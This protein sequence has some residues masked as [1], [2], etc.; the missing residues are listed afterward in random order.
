MTLKAMGDLIL[1]CSM[2]IVMLIARVLSPSLLSS[3]VCTAPHSPMA[4][5]LPRGIHHKY[6]H[7]PVENLDAANLR[8][9]RW[10]L[11]LSGERWEL[12]GQGDKGEGIQKYQLV[13]TKSSYM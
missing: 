3:S 4:Q 12:G 10:G 13:A 2:S 5:V 11:G 7:R 9:V 8:P 1:H 6:L